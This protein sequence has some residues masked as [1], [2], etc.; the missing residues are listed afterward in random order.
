MSEER[1]FSEE[2]LKAL[3]ERTIDRL[4]AAVE[5][6]DRESAKKLA[7]RMY[8]EF[9]AMHDLY[10][11]WVTHL[12]TFVGE[13]F[14]DDSLYDALEET[15]RGYT[16]RLSDR[17]AGKSDRRSIELL[18]AGFR[19][20]LQPF[21]IEEDEEKFIITPHPCGSGERLIRDGGYDPPSNFLRIK[22]PQPMTFNRPDF[23]VYC[24]H[25]ALQNIIPAEPGGSPL[26]VT[27][28]SDD[29]GKEP[30]RI[31]VYKKE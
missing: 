26:F 8:A 25:C 16:Q 2:E 12:L 29:P 28:P 19:G 15:V 30:C 1:L 20:H 10:R 18:L 6:D 3:S 11:D 4:L 22:E 17:Y 27:E 5:S 21:D 23:P 31:Y 24:A 9:L 7:R 13:R 14:G